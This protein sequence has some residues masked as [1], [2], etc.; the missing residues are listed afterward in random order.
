MDASGISD[1]DP[2][3]NQRTAH[4]SASAHGTTKSNSLAGTEVGHVRLGASTESRK[5]H[6]GL[7]CCRKENLVLRTA[8][9]NKHYTVEL[10]DV[11]GDGQSTLAPE[12]PDRPQ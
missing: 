7:R 6:E 5:F 11:L 9:P 2:A 1:L 10:E 8:E 4:T 3:A 12:M